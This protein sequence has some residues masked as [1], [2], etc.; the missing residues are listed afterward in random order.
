MASPAPHYTEC[1]VFIDYSNLWIAGKRVTAKPLKGA[2]VDDRFRVDLGTLIQSTAK[3]RPIT[4]ACLYGSVPPPND[5]V[6]K[7]AR[8][9][10]FRVKILSDREVAG[11]RIKCCH[12]F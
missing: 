6:W 1:Y 3:D 12:G 4:N 8:D 10:N 7:I 11:K 2:K 9:R 5:S